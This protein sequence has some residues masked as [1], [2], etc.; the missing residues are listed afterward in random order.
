MLYL[1]LSTKISN[2][3]T[4]VLGAILKMINSK[5]EINTFRRSFRDEDLYPLWILRGT[6]CDWVL[7]NPGSR[8]RETFTLFLRMFLLLNV[9]CRGLRLRHRLVLT[10]TTVMY[11]AK[12]MFRIIT[13]IHETSIIMNLSVLLI[14]HAWLVCTGLMIKRTIP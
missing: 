1:R 13:N 8:F 11:T 2:T 4:Y 12:T 14:I 7:L 3:L 9:Y 5:T 6:T 10:K